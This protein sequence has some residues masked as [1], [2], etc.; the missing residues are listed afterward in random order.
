MLDKETE[1]FLKKTLKENLDLVGLSMVLY[2]LH[3]KKCPSC[4]M[5]LQERLDLKDEKVTFWG[6][7]QCKQ[8]FTFKKLQEVKNIFKSISFCGQCAF[9]KTPKCLSVSSEGYIKKTDFACCDF[10]VDR[11]ISRG[12]LRKR[13]IVQKRVE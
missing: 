4:F 9:Y 1:E 10:Y 5:E 6:C 8:V 13:K 7:S 11:H 2:D 12:K 3:N